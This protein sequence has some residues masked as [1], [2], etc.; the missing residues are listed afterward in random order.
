MEWPVRYVRRGSVP[1]AFLCQL[2]HLDGIEP[3]PIFPVEA[4]RAA[5]GRRD[6]VQTRLGR[7]RVGLADRLHTRTVECEDQA[8]T[9]IC[10]LTFRR[11]CRHERVVLK[12]A[13][14]GA[15][16]GALVGLA[17]LANAQ[18]HRGRIERF[19]P[20]AVAPVSSSLQF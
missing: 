20:T 8:S 16:K 10:R 11:E 18:H 1:S 14:D 17:G 3:P 15:A 4:I 9:P 2:E 6:Q 19:P 13:V 12:T 5:I 7:V